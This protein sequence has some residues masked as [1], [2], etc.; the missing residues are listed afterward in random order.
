MARPMLGDVELQLV[1]RLETDEDQVLT[2]HEIPALEGD[3]F[4]QQNRRATRLTLTGVLTGPAA[5]EGLKT[6]RDKFRAA[7]PVDFVADISTAT[8][9]DQVLIEEMGVR[10]LAGKPERFEYA[11]TLREYI[12]AEE[13][14]TE[15]P[16]EPEEPEDPADD[17]DDNVGT[18]VV[19]VIVE[20]QPNFDFGRLTVSVRGAQ[21]DGTTLSRNLTNHEGNIWTE[22]NV[23]ASQGEY[24]IEAIETN[25]QALSGATTAAIRVGQTT[26]VSI[27]IRP[28]SNIAKM[29]IIHF[30]FDK[31]FLEPCMRPVLQQ[32]AQYA[33]A[34]PDEKL[35]IVGHTDKAGPPGYNQSLSERR[36]R[37]VFAFLTV[38]VN[39]SDALTDWNALR[40]TRQGGGPSVQDNWGVREY[41][42]I[43]QHL[44][45]Y[46]G[47]VDGDR[48]G[49]GSLTRDAV[50]AYRCHKGL[51]PGTD[52]DD[53]VWRALIEDYLT[54]EPL[55]VP[56]SH[57]FPNCEG[58]ILK[59]LGC[60]E[61]DPLDRRGTAF[62]PSRRVEVLFVRVNNLP[63]EVPQPVTFN[64]PPG[65]MV[66][67]NWCLDSGAATSCCCFVSPH[68]QPNSSQ[69]Q[70]CPT[71]P[72]GP[73]CRQY[74]EPGQI[75]V[76]VSIQRE[77]PNGTLEPVP[78]QRFV[79][80]SPKGEFKAGEQSNGEPSPARTTSSSDPNPGTFTFPDMPVGH[81]SLEVIRPVSS[82]VLVR[83][84]DETDAAVRGNAIC[85]HL[86]PDPNSPTRPVRLDAVIVNAP[87]MREIQLPV[88]AH[89]MTPLDGTSATVRSCP[90]PANPGSTLSQATA[91]TNDEVRE[92]FEEANK[93]WR[94][95]RIRFDPLAIVRSAYIHPIVDPVARGSCEVDNDESKLLLR[96]CAYPDVINIFFFGDLQGTST[97][98]RG[99][100]PENAAA[101]SLPGGG[102]V[103]DRFQATF[104]G[105]LV[106]NTLTRQ[107]SIRVLAHVL[108][109]FLNLAQ[110]ADTPANADRLMLPTTVV[111]SNTTLVDDE[112][113]RA[114]SSQAAVDDC[115][116]LS[117]VV[118][119]ATQI[120]GTFS[121]QYIFVQ[122]PEIVDPFD[123]IVE[124]EI[125]DHFLA[126]GTL[127]MTDG[128][129]IVNGRQFPV[130]KVNT[131]ETTV[132][133][134]YTSASGGQTVTAHVL[135]QVVTFELRVEGATRVSPGSDTF[136]AVRDLNPN[137]IVTITGQINPTPFCV[138]ATL[139]TWTRGNAVPDPL[140]R[141]IPKN[142]IAR[143]VVNAT[144]AGVTRSVT[145]L[146]I[147]VAV[148]SNVSP[149]NI[150][151]ARVQIEGILNANRTSFDI[152][153]LFENQANSLFRARADLPG[154]SGNAVQTRLISNS[155]E[156]TAIEPPQNIMLTRTT[157]D[158]FVS[159]PI[160]AVPAAIPRA[161]ITTVDLEIIRA[162]AGGTIRLELVPTLA[163]LGV[164][165]VQV[166][167]TV[168]YIFAQ[169]FDGSDVNAADVR[170][171]IR[172][173]NRAWAQAGLEVKERQINTA[174]RAPAGL[175]DLDH[176]VPFNGVLTSEERRLVGL[177]PNG[178]ARSNVATDLN[179]YYVDE[180]NG[181]AAGV[182]YN[183]E[184]FSAISDPAQSAIAIEIPDSAAANAA[185]LILAHEMGHNILVNWGGNEH[186]DHAGNDWP[187]N[188]VMHPSVSVQTDLDRTQV[189]NILRSVRL[190]NNPFIVFEP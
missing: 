160:L 105:G 144:I 129:N 84:L 88:V 29:F 21:A 76:I 52:V 166:R 125:P 22:E 150:P 18:L 101:E 75:T 169:A 46:A 137:A 133:A 182:A 82:P 111:G 4:Q 131:G 44:N 49:P 122:H 80:I 153:D 117:L 177:A 68:L 43:L 74:A 27:T 171:H 69:P 98:G 58:E 138:P 7:A 186:R 77:L 15:E 25:P 54:Q 17:I 41:Q 53:D 145:I 127:T 9:V 159:R 73:W 167:G 8:R 70:P 35:L 61:D 110:V 36:A 37:S 147:E 142:T 81:Y 65:A 47:R 119:G 154:V 141:T 67:T 20:G 172:L 165:L 31:A 135:I 136:V 91:R 168:V 26:T 170:R 178:P 185:D 55:A 151:I 86:Q 114:R 164:T 155:P 118:T 113:A 143:T 32:V 57:F 128:T 12:P 38:G 42:H 39:E 139:V 108:G 148:T 92:L 146:I 116:P 126:N 124:A 63:C 189:E 71:D 30:R 51:P 16:P 97:G 183:H 87:V 23:P 24:T 94:Q 163:G 83:L 62:R 179:I 149:F 188:V 48:G 11:F 106:V 162:Q 103:A 112:V 5:G 156:G 3:F 152:G 96:Q 184:G 59:W 173:A 123:I 190:G 60:G 121:H 79:L 19:E 187:S 115:V 45:F 28:T 102:F 132:T 2:R 6:L 72:N 89:L 176:N 134:T 1:Q 130:S 64:L 120:G 157:G 40:Q 34:H 78:N 109:Q 107:Q 14:I 174:V 158:R 161:D 181:P 66:N 33:E 13:V 85:K 104:G 180:I 50:R 10:E 56:P 90:H 140:R 100:S 99:I 175:L 95:A 93:I